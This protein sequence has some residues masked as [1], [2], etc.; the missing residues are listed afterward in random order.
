[1]I[2]LKAG[3]YRHYKGGTYQ[4]LGVAQHSESDELLVVYVSLDESL[5]GPRLRARPVS[6]WNEL[7][8]WPDGATMP[9]FAYVGIE[10]GKTG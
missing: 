9:R 3:L 5:P 7:V 6:M 10:I 1:M 4:A 8:R 2:E